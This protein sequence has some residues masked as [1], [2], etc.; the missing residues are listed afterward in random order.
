LRAKQRQQKAS[1]ALLKEVEEARSIQE[2]LLPLEMPQVQGCDIRATWLPAHDVGGDYF[3]AIQ[4]SDSTVAFC[5]ADVSG[6]GLPAALLMA[7]TQATVRA[8]AAT[9]DSPAE[10]C[11]RL[12]RALSE[13]LSPGKF[14]TMFYAVLDTA[15]MRLRYTN[16]GHL[17]PI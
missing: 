5:I 2:R 8:F 13:N 16:A 9:N 10:M 14:I 15:A 1:Q 4:L 12:N 17:P 7:N 6:K 3:D 11:R